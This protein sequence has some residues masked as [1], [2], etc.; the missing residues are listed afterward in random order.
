MTGRGLTSRDRA[1]VQ[2]L[3]VIAAGGGPLP[4]RFARFA[5]VLG[6]AAG[7][8][9]ATL[10]V[11]EGSGEAVRVAGSW[12]VEHEPAVIGRV[13]PAESVGLDLAG[14]LAAG[15]AF[16]AGEAADHP[17]AV[18]LGR[19]GYGSGW[20]SPLFERGE[21]VGLLVA[22]WRTAELPGERACALLREA[23][24]LLGAAAAR[25]RELRA[26]NAAAAR[27]RAAAEL[28][29]A[30]ARGESFETLFSSL[31]GLLPEALPVDYT[32]LVLRG[33][34]GFAL[35]GEH[36]PGVHAG[37]PPTDEGNAYIEALGRRGDVLQF[38][39]EAGASP[40]DGLALAGYG[41]AAVGILR[42]GS[43]TAGLLIVA[44][45]A[46]RRFDEQELGFIGLLRALL[47]QALTADARRRR[48][49]VEASRAR[50]LNELAAHLSVGT[51]LE[52]VFDDLCAV[53]PQALRYDWVALAAAEPDGEQLRVVGT[54]PE[55]RLRAGMTFPRATAPSIRL[56][57][58]A[59]GI[60]QYRTAESL[61]EFGRMVAAAGYRRGLAALL[62]DGGEL[63]GT[64]HLARTAD[65]PFD[66]PDRAFVATLCRLLAVGVGNRR[67][68]LDTARAYER[69]RILNELA[70][71]LN[72]GE[73]PEAFFEA[74]STRLQATVD[75]D[76]LA[77]WVTAG[78]RHLRV[79]DSLRRRSTRPGYTAP[80]ESFGALLERL[81]ETRVIEAPI[82]EFEGPIAERN[83][84]AGVKRVAA[85]A[86]RHEGE[87][88]GLLL[89]SRLTDRP[90]DPEAI[91]HLEAVAALLGQALANHRKV[92]ERVGEAV[93]RQAL[94]ELTALLQGGQDLREQFEA[95]SRIL[96]QGVGFDWLSITYR[97]PLTGEYRPIR[98][99]P[100]DIDAE[101]NFREASIGETA[102]A[103]GIVQYQTRKNP[104]RTPQALMRAGYRRAA[105]AV[106]TSN[107]GPEGLL[108]IGRLENER[109]DERELEFIQLVAALVGQAA[110]NHR[111]QLRQQR[112]TQQ[113]HI[114]NELALFVNDGAPIEAHFARLSRL[115]LAVEGI[116][117][118]SIAAREPLGERYRLL[119][120]SDPAGAAPV[121]VDDGRV[122]RMLEAGV[123]SAQLTAEE[124]AHEPVVPAELFEGGIG[125][126]AC[127]LLEA[128]G[129]PEGVL[130]IGRRGTQPFDA[131][132]LRFAE[133]AGALLAYAIANRRRV[134]QSAAEAEE[135]R[136]I[137]Q[138]AAAVAREQEPRRLAD[139]LTEAVGGFIPGPLVRIAFLRG[140]EMEVVRER[141]DTVRIPI[142][143]ATA[144]ALETGEPAVLGPDAPVL[145]EV[146]RSEMEN[147]GIATRIV[148]PARA[149][150]ETAGLLLVFSRD[151]AFRAGEREARLVRLI[152]DIVGPALANL[153]A[154]ERQRREAEEQRIIGE[155]AAAV[156]REVD[157]YGIMRGLQQVARAFLP[158]PFAAFGFTREDHIWFP[159]GPLGEVRLP[160]GPAFARALA[161]ETLVLAG[162]PAGT[163]EAAAQL[164][165]FGLR[166][167]VVAPAYSRGEITGLLLL[168]TRDAAFTPGEREARLARLIADIVGPAM[169]N[170]M[171]VERER[172]EA[173]DQAVVAAAA[174][175]VARELDP[176]AIA[177]A[178]QA[179]AR[180]FVPQPYVAFGFLDG[181]QV[182]F[183]NRAGGA[184]AVQL[185]PNF[186]QALD[187]GAA[188]VPPADRRTSP[189]GALPE[190]DSLGIQAHI[191]AAASSGGVPVGLL[192]VGSRDP[193]FAP[194]ERELRLAR[195]IADIVGP[196]MA[197][198]RAA[199][200]ERQDAEDQ[201]LLA[202]IAA[203]AA[204]EGSPDAMVVALQRPMRR[205]VPL[206]IVAFGLKEGDRI[207][208]PLGDGTV[209]ETAP[210][211]YARLAEEEGQTHADR[212]PGDLD[213]RSPLWTMG[214]RAASTT[215]ARAGGRTIGYLVVASRDPDYTF[216]ERELRLLRLI[217]Q[218]VGPAMENARAAQRA[219]EDAEEQRFLADIA[220]VAT[221]AATEQELVQQLGREFRWLVP[222]A[223][224][225]LLIFDETGGLV[226]SVNPEVRLP[227]GFDYADAHA[228]EPVVRTPAEAVTEASR[229][230]Q[231]ELGIVR[232]VN[233]RLAPGGVSMGVLW[234]GTSDPEFRFTARHLRV[235]KLAA[236]IL[237]PAMANL[238]ERR[239][240]IEEA[241]EQRF[242]AD[243]A[244]AAARA[245]TDREFVE[246]LAA[247]FRRLVPRAM[248]GFFYVEGEQ[249]RD[250]A[251]GEAWPLGPGVR[252]AIEARQA[253]DTL[254]SPDI[255]P[256]N[257]ERIA[258]GGLR[259]WVTT[260]AASEGEVIGVLIVGTA[261]EAYAF[262][263]RDLR[264]CRLVA[265]IAGPAMANFRERRRRLEEAEDE[266]I[267]AS[268]AAAAA[269]ARTVGEVV[270]H[271][272]A[273]L[274]ERV[275]GA[276][277]MY[278]FVRGDAIAYQ[279]T[280][281]EGRRV[282][283]RDELVMRFS[284]V[285]REALAA[286]QGV[287]NLEPYRATFYGE[288]GLC[289]YAL[290][291][292]HAAGGVSGMLMVASRDPA[293]RFGPRELALLRRVTAVVG[294]VVET[295]TAQAERDRQ[296]EEQRILAE[297][298]ATAAT[299]QG[300]TAI[301]LGITP[302]LERFVP[303]AFAAYG[304]FDGD[305]LAWPHLL[306][307]ELRLP[308]LP[309]EFEA[310]SV[311]QVVVPGEAVPAS[312]FGPNFGFTSVSYT[313]TYSAGAATGLL[314]VASREPG[315]AFSE[316]DL[317]L[318]RRVAQVV[319]PAIEASIATQERERQAAVYGL[320][321][322]SLSEAVIL[323][324]RTG[325]PIFANA[326]G[327][328]IVQAIDPDKTANDIDAIA[329]RLPEGLREP[330]RRAF[331]DGVGAR[332]RAE[333]A[334][335]GES[336]HFDYEFVPL[337][338]PQ[339]RVLT[340]AADVT[341]EVRREAEE[342]ANRARMERASRLAALGELIGGVAHELN[343]PLT[344]ILGF[345]EV[346]ALSDTTGQMGEELAIIQKEAL[347]ARN[348]VR[349]LLFIARP[350]AAEHGRVAVADVVGHVQRLRERLWQ[351]AGIEVQVRL[352]DGL[353][354]WG[355]EHQLTQVLLN[356]VT[357]AEHA[358][359]GRPVRR[360]VI[361]GETDEAGNVRIAVSDTGTGMDEA[362]R[363]RIFEPFFTTK[364]GVGT[365]LGLPLSY[366]IIQSHRGTIDCISTPGTGTTF[367]I[368]LPA[369][370]EGGAAD[371]AVEAPPPARQATVLVI[372]D[373][374]SL[375]KV[376]RRLVESLGHR[377]LDA[378]NSGRALELAAEF[379]PDVIL[380]DY[381]LATE[382]ADAVFEGL[383]ARMPHLI[384]RAIIATGATT[385]A[386][387]TALVER[388]GL[389]LLAK[390]YGVEDIARVIRER[391]TGAEESA[392][393]AGQAG[394]SG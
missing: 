284:P 85:V 295:V 3:A 221:R 387:V 304:R 132:E 233:A 279:V 112:R 81:R 382:T 56:P 83:R 44:R 257:R 73:G 354:A 70:L 206:P 101:P 60:Y 130:T 200:R 51:P 377:C 79:V 4:E 392:G 167:H 39:P 217:A 38:R 344:A 222:A 22:G 103:G 256:E 36:P 264:L 92:R 278:G 54:R 362:T 296:A 66:A 358:L 306:G 343:N 12:P 375:R 13:L 282:I 82:E 380:C 37:L 333:L 61:T 50:A 303:K 135:Q 247:T 21:P 225:D 317:A 290:T 232:S 207:L 20:V 131:D 307:G 156:A 34:G 299:A 352:A 11:S 196:A 109:F 215:A 89:M 110:A 254:D 102:Q 14:Q 367:V 174:A 46:H 151:A 158:K 347:R 118:V 91:G 98:S 210:D 258:A 360:I 17:A 184:T 292:Y 166:A 107:E 15:A 289:A 326:L 190:L 178:L 114:L 1:V 273:V 219:R 149:G 355:N 226:S 391:V 137:A 376:C 364:Q 187:D 138:A 370:S 216:G 294:P 305:E 205:L 185:G 80:R 369:P 193:E 136:I 173:E 126:I 322:R 195:L 316:R 186:R 250:A 2:E 27:A 192:V 240:R 32:G 191:I 368:T 309:H 177:H 239:R 249:L 155:A 9:L 84:A 108:T 359:E 125:R 327:Q 261:D 348:I 209:F 100:M 336:R 223:R 113:E 153:L 243:A 236:D 171:A 159:G 287:G 291:S 88:E 55:G 379:D 293:F 76:G 10:F 212:L 43:E 59:D 227:V 310:R 386:G 211:Q 143:P 139:A 95:L 334:I 204:R 30:L 199:E 24:A 266:R 164:E 168:G 57:F 353:A 265:D 230:R 75:F 123:R 381:R 6:E 270:N 129:E 213:P 104:N 394:S 162:G 35:A 119:R 312:H 277:A 141:D 74:L 390:P 40:D 372:D 241:E 234:L 49:A 7:C 69:A 361:E 301:L 318:I 252:R 331:E 350:G 127:V 150:G 142:G 335:D 63:V 229:Q 263:E 366:S 218:I 319:G 328:E 384:P 71:L 357:N 238:R 388:Y 208:Y 324:D 393:G 246:G 342:A 189:A 115:L 47:S 356:L 228:L 16:A 176:L 269:A 346:L 41:R 320:I 148:A 245:T 157:A 180:R 268:V 42:E 120:S 53:L 198:A 314:L 29:A 244:A 235:I 188:V 283:G 340:V 389:E 117:L 28:G 99:K 5:A 259:R 72:R 363:A 33:P 214:A 203:V 64:L 154:E 181:A 329:A 133:L 300:P 378:E 201:R 19:L 286:G 116:D 93:R 146:S 281:P 194:G 170:A 374:P 242:L 345:A 172:Q 183:P 87:E 97:D 163:P 373:E 179:V 330:F 332:G 86:L 18:S 251:S 145:F 315:F 31:A 147:S 260:A 68:L 272:P 152:A 298:S 224:L 202:E 58:D 94:S 325:R 275:P 323:S 337:D 106:M 90:L 128:G 182:Q 349:D 169:A 271:L 67:R 121:F 341:D 321:L 311:G 62:Q 144:R 52:Q 288:L 197:N 253:V 267:V 8:A 220:A 313:A 65:E 48:E 161:G 124:A 25:E 351:Q 105:T 338:D 96:L 165:R 111:A 45:R 302:A 140:S 262:T 78:P 280:D 175:A 339:M 383:E 285:G 122:R 23:A 365:G 77:L 276:Y 160:I 134:E 297:V 248:A 255:L 26:A 237:G 274:G 385:D 231:R 371:A 308:M